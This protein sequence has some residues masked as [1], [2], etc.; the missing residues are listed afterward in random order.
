MILGD[1]YSSL[2]FVQT[3]GYILIFLIM[4]FEGPIITTA[5][6][7]A[8][9]L[10]FFNIW[11]IFFLSLAG[12]LIGDF[13]HYGLGRIGRIA[14]VEKLSAKFGIKNSSIKNLEKKLHLHLGKGMFFI[15]FVP[16]FTTPG[17]MLAGALRVP[18]KRFIF[19]SFLLTLPRTIFFTGLGFFFGAAINAV[20]EYFKLG[21][22]A[23]SFVVVAV[24][25][26]YFAFRK[27][28]SY[29]AKKN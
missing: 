3:H 11:V 15:K 12:D 23:V 18:A 22:Y 10:G 21:Q 26:I 6:A 5:A 25:I 13:L 2:S 16:V 14:F 19:Y 8:A 1:F 9:S 27:I 28:S 17:L 20:L 24:I 29:I 7:F 4:I